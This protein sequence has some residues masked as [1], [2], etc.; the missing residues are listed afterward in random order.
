MRKKH[1]LYCS[2]ITVVI[3]I[4]FGVFRIRISE[5][6]ASAILTVVSI[7]FGFIITAMTMLLNSKYLGLTA[8]RIDKLSKNKSPEIL[9][10][11]KYFKIAVVLSL[12]N[13]CLTIIYLC[14]IGVLG[15]IISITISAIIVNLV[16]WNIVIILLMSFVVINIILSEA[17]HQARLDIEIENEEKQDNTEDTEIL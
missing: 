17:G 12:S 13:L 4:L 2:V 7:L 6:F 8:K 15:E 9:T 11:I 16:S 3:A 5:T 1:I 14:L 10:I